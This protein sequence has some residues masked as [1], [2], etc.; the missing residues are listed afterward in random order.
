MLQMIYF[1]SAGLINSP[2]ACWAP[3]PTHPA[4]RE[5]IRG[6]C[7]VSFSFG[8][9]E[10][11]FVLSLVLFG[12]RRRPAHMYMYTGIFRNGMCCLNNPPSPGNERVARLLHLRTAGNPEY[13]CTALLLR[14]AP[15]MHTGSRRERPTNQPCPAD[16]PSHMWVHSKRATIFTSI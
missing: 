14:A 10:Y 6:I 2:R 15:G 7:P 12:L 13:A 4:C 1:S 16:K 3:L 11:I 9:C 8:C 5:N